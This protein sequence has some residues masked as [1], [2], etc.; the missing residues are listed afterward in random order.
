MRIPRTL[1]IVAFIQVS[2]RFGYVTFRTC[3]YYFFF[4]KCLASGRDKS[5]IQ[6]PWITL[7]MPLPLRI[8]FTNTWLFILTLMSKCHG[9]FLFFLTAF[10]WIVVTGLGGQWTVF[11]CSRR[12][13]LSTFKAKQPLNKKLALSWCLQN[14]CHVVY[15]YVVV[16][17][18][19]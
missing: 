19:E 4:P 5:V 10:I 17:Y 16:N 15:Q 7:V 3:F 11:F 13:Y 2:D 8:N 6:G 9:I 18:K 12:I 14:S 1:E